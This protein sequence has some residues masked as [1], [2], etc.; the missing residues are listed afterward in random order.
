MRLGSDLIPRHWF[1]F[2]CIFWIWIQYDSVILILQ[3][4]LMF[5]CLLLGRPLGFYRI[6]AKFETLLLKACN[7]LPWHS[8]LP[9]SKVS[10]WKFSVDFGEFWKRCEVITLQTFDFAGQEET[11]CSFHFALFAYVCL[12][13]RL[14]SYVHSEC[15]DMCWPY[16]H[17]SCR[18]RKYCTTALSQS[19]EY[20]MLHHIFM[21]NKAGT[22]DKADI[23]S[24]FCAVEHKLTQLTLLLSKTARA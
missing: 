15:V 21:S 24:Q 4:S 20:H 12:I 23:D 16:R 9:L 7:L 6:C 5:R 1:R 19:Q 17:H 11:F 8:V 14:Y 10:C 13:S 22:L 3:I 2:G 18:L